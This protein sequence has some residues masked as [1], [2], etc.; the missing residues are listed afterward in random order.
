MFVEFLSAGAPVRAARQ[1]I[2]RASAKL[3]YFLQNN[4]K[5]ISPMAFIILHN[6]ELNSFTVIALYNEHV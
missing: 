6:A 5:C 4:S 2:P 1:V 3:N